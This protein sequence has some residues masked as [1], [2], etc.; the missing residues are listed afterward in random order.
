M[1]IHKLEGEESGQVK[2]E[3]LNKS[4]GVGS[5]VQIK[6]CQTAFKKHCTPLRPKAQPENVTKPAPGYVTTCLVLLGYSGA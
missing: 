2:L 3:Y 1:M 5:K 6:T 4:Q